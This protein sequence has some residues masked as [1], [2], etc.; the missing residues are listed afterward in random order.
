MWVIFYFF[1][2]LTLARSRKVFFDPSKMIRL[3]TRNPTRFYEYSYY[4]IE[5]I[6]QNSWFE[7]FTLA[8]FFVTH[9]FWRL[10]LPPGANRDHPFSNPFGPGSQDL[11]SLSLDPILVVVGSDDLLRDRAEYYAKKLKEWRKHIEFIE[12][13]GQ[14][15]GF[16]L[17]NPSSEESEKLNK[18]MEQFIS[19]ISD[20]N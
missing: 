7:C 3:K 5:K 11:E 2:P 19:Q 18:I 13:K 1:Y 12:F 15:H 17:T 8:W 4:Y 10:S 14:K 20:S 6:S 16:S 9:R